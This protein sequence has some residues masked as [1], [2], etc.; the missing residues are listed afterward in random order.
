MQSVNNC[1]NIDSNPGGGKPSYAELAE[2]LA[3]VLATYLE[4]FTENRGNVPSQK[5]DD[6]ISY[7]INQPVVIDGSRHWIRANT[8]QEFADKVLSLGRHVPDTAKHPFTAYAWNWYNTYAVPN[9]ATVTATTYKRQ[10]T[11]YII[12]AFDNL[13]VEDITVD[14]VQQLFN[15]MTGAKAT[16]DK[17]KVVLNQIF[18]FAVEDKLLSKNPLQSKR[19]KIT[20]KASKETEP[21][22]VEQ[23][24]YLIQHI[25]DIKRPDDRAYLAIHALHPLRPEEVLG[26]QFG[27]IDRENMTLHVRRAVT[28]PD[29]SKPEVKDTKTASS[30]RVLSLSALALPYLP[31]GEAGQ[32]LFGNDQPFC[33]SRVRRMCERI[34]HDIAFDENITPARFRTTVLTDLYDQMK[35][36]KLAQAAAGHT[37]S[38]MTLKH[39]VKGRESSIQATAAVERAY[40]A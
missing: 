2:Q 6:T 29:R 39:Y 10:L 35:D 12:P 26:L 4:N 18:S 3:P 23:M 14:A 40:T 11:K 27:D 25:G 24:R 33:Y 7:K 5:G 38:A 9:I 15:S 28:H 19:L 8:M 20:G 13:S 30:H 17:V 22:T 31:D 36:I 21:Y 37:T 16:K 34:Q 32:F 1:A